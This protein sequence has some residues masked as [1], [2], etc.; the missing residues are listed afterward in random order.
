MIRDIDIKEISDG[1]LYEAN[2]M[3]KL[4]V[5]DCSGCHA[6]CCGMGDTIVLDPYDIFSLERGLGKSFDELQR[7]H[8][9]LRVVDGIILPCMKME[10]SQMAGTKED[11][12]TFLDTNGR[13]SIHSF[14]PGFCRLFPMG[15]IYENGTHRYFLQV[16][17]CQKVRQNKIK[18]KKW[19]GIPEFGRYE[20]YID[21]WHSFVRGISEKASQM[22]QDQLKAINMGLLKKFFIDSYNENEDFYS[23]F[24]ERM[25]ELF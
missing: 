21:D 25:N 14:R 17:E 18:I 6:C 20:K 22:P 7:D 1:R 12:C 24:D 19:I 2:D 3:A 13:C 9:E 11:A 8:L 4:G 5:N 16:N 10:P 15:R 23:Q